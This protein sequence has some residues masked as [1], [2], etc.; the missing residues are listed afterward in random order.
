MPPVPYT[1]T[2]ERHVQEITHTCPNCPGQLTWQHG[3]LICS[4]CGFVPKH[5]A[6]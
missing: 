6:D 3:A 2:P 1:D 4:G 5:G